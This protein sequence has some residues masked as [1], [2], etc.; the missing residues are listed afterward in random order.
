MGI[1]E[2]ARLLSQ[3]RAVVG[4]DTGLTHLAA[5][6]GARTIG[7]Y[8]GSNPART[9]LYGARGARNLGGEGDAPSAG[10]VREALAEVPA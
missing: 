10:Q 2:L 9:G 5:A 6:L 1:P 7:V 4:V 3:A 8:C